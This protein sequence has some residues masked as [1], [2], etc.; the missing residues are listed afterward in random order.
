VNVVETT[1]VSAG[2]Q[3]VA[4]AKVESDRLMVIL[5]VVIESQALEAPPTIVSLNETDDE[6]QVPNTSVESQSVISST[7]KAVGNK[8]VVT[9]CTESHEAAF[10]NVVETTPVSAGLQDVAEAKVE[11]DRLIVI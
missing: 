11:S 6:Y 9:V 2:L 3:E 10:V 1:P 8:V 5:N 4:V 7:A